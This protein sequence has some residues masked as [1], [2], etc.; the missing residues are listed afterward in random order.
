M[1]RWAGSCALAAAPAVCLSVCPLARPR[2][3]E[4]QR[5]QKPAKSVWEQRTSEMRKQNLL[6]SR[7]ALYPEL[8]PEERWK[9]TYAR[10]LRPDVKTHLD[11]PLVVDPQEN[12]NNNTNKSRAAE[13]PR[14]PPAAEELLRKRAREPPSGL[15]DRRPWGPDAD[16][17]ADAEPSREGP[18]G[19]EAEPPGFWEA[20]CAPPPPPPATT[21]TE[22]AP[23]RPAAHAHA[24]VHAHRP[25]APRDGRGG[26]PRAGADGE[27]RRHRARRRPGDDAGDDRERDRDRAERRLRHRDGDGPP[28]AGERRRRHRH[29]ALAPCDADARRDDK[30]RRHRRRK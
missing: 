30:E 18:Y 15:A 9:A 4:Q 12:R 8:A 24:H 2:R 11:R 25:G 14:A 1:V 6:A 23:R 13:P 28:E 26:S 22:D 29:G 5:N 27:P 20:E 19:R 17:D 10:H 16:A 3:K 21:T 7:E